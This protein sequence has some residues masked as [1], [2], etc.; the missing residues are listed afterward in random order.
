MTVEQPSPPHLAPGA[1]ALLDHPED[2]RIRAIR[3][4]RWVGFARARRVLELMQVLRDHPPSTRPPG[5]AIFAHSGMGKTMLVE[6][7]RRDHPPII[8]PAH[9]LETIPVLGITLTSRPSERRIYAQLLRALDAGLEQR[10]VSWA[11]LETRA[12]KL[13]KQVDVR[14]LVFDEVHNL[15]ASSPREQRV[16][17]QLFRFLSNELKAS[18][19][20]LGIADTRE[21]IAGDTQLL[22]RLDQL[23][24]PRWRADEEF[25]ALVTAVLRSVPLR[26]PSALSAQS[27]R[28]LAR[29]T[30]GITAQ[31]FSTLN[32]LAIEAVRTGAERITDEAVEAWRPAVD[33]EAAFS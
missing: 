13:L 28:H 18:L 31:I 14:V 24:L 20:C 4:E 10:A 17:L 1:A 15:L 21:A 23:A 29:I 12:L 2:I 8:H 7:F 16:I 11:E 26:R 25:Q 3:T 32:E 19:V 5:L 33:K 9:G 30:D 6:K 22:R 27:L